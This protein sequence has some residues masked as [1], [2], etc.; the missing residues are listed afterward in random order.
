MKSKY[1][2]YGGLLLIVS[3]LCFTI[4][5]LWDEKRAGEST[6]KLL[7]QYRELQAAPL[8]LETEVSQGSGMAAVEI[9]NNLYIGVLEIP[10]LSISLPVMENWSYDGLKI[11]PCRYQ[12]SVSL[13]NMIIA[14]HNY[15]FHFGGLNKLEAGAEVIFTDVQEKRSEY[16]VAEVI[17]LDG[18]DVEGLENGEW[19]L[20]LFTC[21]LDSQRR[22]VVRCKREECDEQV[23][24]NN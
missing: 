3:A 2:I 7:L 20:T 16:R 13:D 1:W 21:T 15:R 19:D 11:A 9:E 22:V 10:F 23:R 14:A 18:D 4:Y 17:R 6:E 5:N 8:D 24:R 12:G